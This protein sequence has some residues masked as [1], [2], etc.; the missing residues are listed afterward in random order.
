VARWRRFLR[1][2]QPQGVPW[3]FSLLYDA[4]SR[5]FAFQAHYER[6]AQD[7]AASCAEGVLLD[8]GTGLGWLLLR[9]NARCPGLRLVGVDI[10]AAMVARARRNIAEAGCASRKRHPGPEGA[11]RGRVVLVK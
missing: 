3:P 9:L 4:L 10:S 6:V 7:I 8:I 2:I 1:R 11:A 5:T